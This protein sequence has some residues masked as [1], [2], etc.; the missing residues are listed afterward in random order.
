[1]TIVMKAMVSIM[2]EKEIFEE[3]EK[4][5]VVRDDLDLRGEKKKE[6]MCGPPPEGYRSGPMKM[7]DV[8]EAF[9]ARDWATVEMDVTMYE[10]GSVPLRV[11]ANEATDN[12]TSKP[13]MMGEATMAWVDEHLV[14]VTNL[15]PP[16]PAE[17]QLTK[18]QL[19]DAMYRTGAKT[20][21][22]HYSTGGVEAWD[23]IHDAGLNFD[24]GCIV[25]Y[26][27]RHRRKDGITD[28]KKAMSY[29]K[30]LALDVYGE[31]L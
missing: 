8:A 19:D 13:P 4:V 3:F 29:L 9:Q 10:D 14:K 27:A 7:D 2:S 15:P 12:L 1:M 30:A 23:L 18:Q 21:D 31:E 25:K 20:K 24:E 5:V 6:P 22:S 26:V 17:E 28:L 16:G 11:A